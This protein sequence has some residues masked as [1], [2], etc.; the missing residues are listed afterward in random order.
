[1]TLNVSS[2]T[3]ARP[4]HEH[5]DHVQPERFTPISTPENEQEECAVCLEKFEADAER[6]RCAHRIH[7]H[8]AKGILESSQNHAC[9]LCRAPMSHE[10]VGLEL[11]AA[12][13]VPPTPPQ[14]AFRQRHFE[15]F[16]DL[17]P[18]RRIAIQRDFIPARP[19]II[20][21]VPARRI[22]PPRIPVF[23]VNSFFE[24]RPVQRRYAR[25]EQLERMHPM[26]MLFTLLSMM[27]FIQ[28]FS[29]FSFS[30]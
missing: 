3:Q 25:I 7:R 21:V 19:M 26:N 29:R 16:D 22:A 11:P 15:A 10:D 27:N 28:F 4:S 20:F 2:A 24:P 12:P 18:R 9:P 30:R 1:M 5:H 23:F 13:P 14:P 6:L 17:R 8:C